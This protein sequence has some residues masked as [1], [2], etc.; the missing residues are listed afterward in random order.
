[1][2]TNLKHDRISHDDF[3]EWLGMYEDYVPKDMEGLE[4]LRLEEVPDVLEMRRN[5]G[6]AFLE[7]TEVTAL[8]EWKLKHGT[9]RPNLAK[10]VAGNKMQDVRTTTKNAFKDYAAENSR[11]AK[12]ITTLTKLKGIGPATAS[13]L[14]A[15]YDPAKVPFFSDEL[16]RYMHWSDTN[17][18]GWDRKISYTMKEYKDLFEKVQVLRQRLEKESGQAIKVIDIEKCAYALAKKAEQDHK[19]TSKND[20]DDQALLPPSPK[21]RKRDTSQP[22]QEPSPSQICL[23]KGPRG[24]PTFDEMGYELDYEYVLKCQ[25]RPR[26]LSKRQMARL[27]EK[28]KESERKKKIMWADTEQVP[29]TE[30]TWDDRVA[31]DLGI[32]YHEVGVEEYE[33]WQKKGFHVE[34]GE[35]ENPSQEEQDRIHKLM[36][37]CALR[38]GSKHR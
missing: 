2:Q 7:K 14:L 29:S 36:V 20:S 16:F 27:D 31:R 19:N 13:L 15:C 12:S 17:T 24:S 33:E 10:L 37:G 3:K 26:P 8:V 5:D 22:E 6:D 21:R 38:K 1:M 9:Y 28:G 32:A 23:R 30:P 4:Q 35:F 25:G 18:R 11:F 34:A